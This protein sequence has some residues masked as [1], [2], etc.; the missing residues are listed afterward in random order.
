M[1][2]TGSPSTVVTPRNF[3]NVLGRCA[4]QFS[5]YSQHDSQEFCNFVLDTLH[6]DVNRVRSKPYVAN[7]EANGEPDEQ[8]AREVTIRHRQRNDS[9]IADLFEGLFKSTVVCPKC[10]KVSVTFDPYM[11]LAVPLGGAQ[12]RRFSVTL[13]RR[14]GKMEQ[15]SAQL[16]RHAAVEAL[17]KD[18]AQQTGL[19]A[20]HL[21]ACELYNNKVHRLLAE[22]ELIERIHDGDYVFIYEMARPASFAGGSPSS[23]LSSPGIGSSKDHECSSTAVS[24]GDARDIP[25]VIVQREPQTVGSYSTNRYVGVPILLVVSR[26]VSGAALHDLVRHELRQHLSAGSTQGGSTSAVAGD[27]SNAEKV[28]V[29]MAAASVSESSCNDAEISEMQTGAAGGSWASDADPASLGVDGSDEIRADGCTE[30]RPQDKAAVWTLPWTLQRSSSS[31]YVP[32]SEACIGCDDV[33]V[34]A[35]ETHSTYARSDPHY[36]VLTWSSK[37]FESGCV[38]DKIDADGQAAKAL[39][40]GRSSTATASMSLSECLALFSKEEVLDADNAWYCPCCKEHREGRKKLEVWSL[41]SVLVVHLKRFS[42]QGLSRR[43]LDTFV[44]FPIQGLNLADFCLQSIAEGRGDA[45][46]DLL[47]VSNH[48]GSTSSGHYTAFCNHSERDTWYSCNDSQTSAVDASS[49]VTNSAYVLI[50]RRRESSQ[51]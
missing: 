51:R 41:P 22:Q 20:Q 36:L 38:R 25:I 33:A 24:E 40:F 48:Y 30:T 32:T 27:D 50:Y 35:E 14:N 18:I 37:A 9:Y 21:V 29:V 45:V 31:Y 6:E 17:V 23:R 28:D 13:R 2:W 47:A 15:L 4:P 49:V 43:K 46:Y 44:D 11:S 1:M 34:F 42:T 5:G 7:F 3:K 10:D 8:V 39:A 16:P 19:P 26:S 12:T